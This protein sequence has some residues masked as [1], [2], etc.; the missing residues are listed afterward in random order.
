MCVDYTYLNKACL[1]DAYPLPS[2]D[3]LV[4]GVSDYAILSFLN[5]YSGY[6]QIMMY[7]PV[8][9]STVLFVTKQSNFL[10]LSSPS[11]SSGSYFQNEDD[12]FGINLEEA[13]E[14]D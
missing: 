14:E 11:S 1:K 13:S 9:E 3:R 6:N 4:D 7:L 5:V 8:E 2:I 10:L 12:C